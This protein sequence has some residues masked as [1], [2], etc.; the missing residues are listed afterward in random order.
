MAWTGTTTPLTANSVWTSNPIS[1]KRKAWIRGLIFADQSGSLDVQ[2]SSDGTRW[3]KEG[4][5]VSYTGGTGKSFEA[6]IG[7][8]AWVRLVYTNG[9]TNQG[10]FEANARLTDV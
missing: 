7:G 9:G 2:V 5:S 8:A 3:I 10:V 4:S 1:T 6:R